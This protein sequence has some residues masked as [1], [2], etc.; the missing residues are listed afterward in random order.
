MVAYKF[1]IRIV[2]EQLTVFRDV[3]VNAKN[4]IK[5]LTDFAL[6]SFGFDLKHEQNCHLTSTE[7][8]ISR[9]L[10]QA[11][12]MERP[13]DAVIED[14]F[15]H[16]LLEYDTAKNWEFKIRLLGIEAIG[17]Q[18]Y[19]YCCKEE[20]EAPAQYSPEEFAVLESE[21]SL[22]DKIRYKSSIRL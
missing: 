2:D 9:T 10:S 12:M 19:P 5:D 20:G 7:W 13:L 17:T 6:Q 14:P 4:T 1:R 22:Q 18:N 16:L 21:L 11:E 3:V 8:R 15:Q